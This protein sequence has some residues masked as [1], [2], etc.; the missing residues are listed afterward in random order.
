MPLRMQGVYAGYVPARTAKAVL[1]VRTVEPERGLC[2]G[3]EVWCGRMM[4]EVVCSKLWPK[5]IY[6]DKQHILG[7]G[8]YWRKWGERWWSGWGRTGGRFDS[9]TRA[10]DTR[11]GVV[12]ERDVGLEVAHA[13]PRVESP[14]LA[15]GSV[16]ASSCVCIRRQFGKRV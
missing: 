8:R 6:R 11:P 1:H 13:F 3:V 9:W 10:R 15:V 16:V 14:R 2:K 5:V 12:R 4:L 7:V